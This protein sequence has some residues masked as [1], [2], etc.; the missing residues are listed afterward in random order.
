[1]FLDIILSINIL[2]SNFN[3][4]N[5]SPMFYTGLFMLNNYLKTRRSYEKLCVKYIIVT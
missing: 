4:Y 3:V 5:N 1:M 2:C